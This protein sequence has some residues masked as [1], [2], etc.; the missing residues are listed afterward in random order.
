MKLEAAQLVRFRSSTKKGAKLLGIGIAYY[1]FVRLTGWSI[2][3]LI[4]LITGVLCPGCG[5][6]RMFLA[7]GELDFPKAFHNNA[8]ILCLMPFFIL[9]GG[10]QWLRYVKKGDTG[11]DKLEKCMLLIASALTITFWVLRNLPAF[12]FLAPI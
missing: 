10:R 9:F 3:C 1:I 2:P 8:L 4:T 6:T 5:V 12:S 11:M 7:L